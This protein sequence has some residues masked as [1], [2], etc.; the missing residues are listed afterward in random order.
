MKAPGKCDVGAWRDDPHFQTLKDALVARTGHAYY[1]DK[2][3]LLWE[4]LRRRLSATRRDNLATYLELLQAEDQRSATEWALLEA[5][6]TIGETY[7]FRYAEQF[8]ALRDHILPT[9]IASHADSRRLRIWSAGCSTG[10]EPYSL[11]IVISELLGERL[12]DWRVSILGTDLSEPALEKAREARYGS[13]ALRTVTPDQRDRYFERQDATTWRLRSSY[14]SLVRFQRHNLVTL[15]D[16]DVP[17]QFSDFD[18]ILC[19]NVLIYFH[20]DLGLRVVRALRDR[21]SDVG[22]LILGHADANPWHADLMSV[23]TFDGAVAY[24]K[25]AASLDPAHM[26]P[27]PLS[28]EA[29]QPPSP[30]FAARP[31]ASKRPPAPA[32]P[33]RPQ[34]VPDTAPD[35][36]A[37]DQVRHLADSG[38]CTDAL[39][40]ARAMREAQAPTPSLLY[41]LGLLETECGSET[42]AEDALR[43]ALYLDHGFVMAHYQMGLLLSRQGRIAAARRS[44]GNA[45]RLA[46]ARP[47]SEILPESDGLSAAS[48]HSMARQVLARHPQH[49]GNA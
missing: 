44:I 14:R 18:L 33:E 3:D 25:H 42:R 6:V 26:L 43:S 23:Q 34:P 38:H 15:L 13:W 12:P 31:A 46:A 9:L 17:L 39:Q 22:W 11:A 1:Q 24:R 45:A 40:R 27:M 29:E 32:R 20:P 48:L 37:F 49:E 10:A 16:P 28:A 35:A 2:D 36:T 8:A 19:R 4:R 41:Y 47:A 21:L 7:F 5:E 30:A